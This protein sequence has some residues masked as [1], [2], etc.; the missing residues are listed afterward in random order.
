M[1]INDSQNKVKDS[2]GI[3]SRRD[4]L[5]LGA[6]GSVAMAGALSS[7]KAKAREDGIGVV[8]HD[9]FPLQVAP[10]Y[11]RFN[12]AL[13]VSAVEYSKGN[14]YDTL[15][16]VD[17]TIPGFG[18]VDHAIR[19]GAEMFNFVEVGER[20]NP[21]GAFPLVIEPQPI[22]EGFK[23][24][25]S[26]EAHA[27]IKRAARMYGADIVGITRRDPR[28]DYSHVFNDNTLESKSWEEAMGFEPKTVVVMG[29]AEDYDAFSAAPSAA[30]DTTAD[31]GYARM[32]KA[33]LE[34]AHFFSALGC[35]AAACGNGGGLSVPYAIAAGLGESNRMGLLQNYKFASRLRI[36]KVYVDLELDEY[37]DKPVTFGVQ[38]FCENCMHC[39]DNCPGKAIPRDIKPSLNPPPADDGSERYYNNPGVY[40]W[41]VRCDKCYQYWVDSGTGCGTCVTTCPYNK[42]DFWHHRLIDRVNTILPG[43]MHAFMAEMDLWHGY[44]NVFDPE[45]V[46]TFYDQ[47]GRNYSGMGD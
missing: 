43:F 6:A 11:K 15:K 46:K 37:F 22:N 44:G 27:K 34:L 2:K 3:M 10:T 7:G 16:V 38:S 47:S 41:W 23:F 36:A 13:S 18:T 12:E 32:A 9:S 42:P 1:S 31:E 25:S 19:V 28:W 45:A 4:I 35:K 20:L 40:K 5:K 21:Y 8:K 30:A 24:Q 17:D 39:A 29:F 33:A 14:Y 26:E